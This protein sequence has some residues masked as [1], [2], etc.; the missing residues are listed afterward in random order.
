MARGECTT[1]HENKASYNTDY[2]VLDLRHRLKK[3]I[4]IFVKNVLLI[5]NWFIVSDFSEYLLRHIEKCS[6]HLYFLF[7]TKVKF[8]TFG[9]FQLPNTSEQLHQT[10]FLSRIYFIIFVQRCD[11]FKSIKNHFI[12]IKKQVM[13]TNFALVMY[14]IREQ[15]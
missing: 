11:I 6:S 7:K 12:K 8:T 1:K 2:I 13:L 10:N 4:F 9:I 3:E 15:Y 5:K 14:M